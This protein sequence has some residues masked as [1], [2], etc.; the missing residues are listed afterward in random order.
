MPIVL[1]VDIQLY[2]YIYR[3]KNRM[4]GDKEVNRI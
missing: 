1:I 2:L 3:C 4:I